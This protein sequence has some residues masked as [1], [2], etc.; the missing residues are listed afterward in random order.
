M[1]NLDNPFWQPDFNHSQLYIGARSRVVCTH[2]CQ[3]RPSLCRGGFTEWCCRLSG[4]NFPMNCF[5][6][7]CNLTCVT[8]YAV[9]LESLLTCPSTTAPAAYAA[10]TNC[11]YVTDYDYDDDT[12]KLT[13]TNQCGLTPALMPVKM[14]E[15]GFDAG[16]VSPSGRL[17]PSPASA[18][19]SAPVGLAPVCPYVSNPPVRPTARNRA[20]CTWWPNP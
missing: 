5:A 10:L 1:D 17:P 2:E 19:S 15:A 13:V 9:L 12:K 3:R 16:T 18:H 14:V 7:L 4:F 8:P 20:W 11:T 6:K